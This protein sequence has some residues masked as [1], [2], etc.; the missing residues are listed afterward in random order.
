MISEAS[1]S[2]I[3]LQFETKGVEPSILELSY[4]DVYSKMTNTISL[5][6][7][8]QNDKLIQCNKSIQIES[9]AYK[10]YLA[11]NASQRKRKKV[12]PPT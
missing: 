9:N 5:L 8:S 6:Q 10:Q 2:G 11:T 1:V 4:A 12:A 7:Y 3:S